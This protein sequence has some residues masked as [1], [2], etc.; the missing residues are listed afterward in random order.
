MVKLLVNH[1]FVLEY[2]ILIRIEPVLID[3][4]DRSLSSCTFVDRQ[5]YLGKSSHSNNFPDPIEVTDISKV[6]QD[7]VIRLYE[8]LIDVCDR[9]VVS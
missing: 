1:H 6:L 3:H 8:D 9:V 7:E 2:L 4:F 5:S